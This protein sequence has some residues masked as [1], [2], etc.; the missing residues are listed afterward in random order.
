MPNYISSIRKHIGN[1]L[2]ICPAARIIIENDAGEYLFIRRID[3]GQIGLPAGAIEFNESIEQCIRREVKEETGLELNV[4]KVIGISSNPTLELA[5]YPNGDATQYLC[6]EFY[7]KE[8]IGEP[9]ADDVESSEVFFGGAEQIELL[10]AN[11]R[12]TFDSLQYY[13]QHNQVLLK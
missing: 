4:V 7:A 5:H 8:Y 2:F 9:K 3:N 6:V 11:E 12:S 10:P 1:D 13:Q